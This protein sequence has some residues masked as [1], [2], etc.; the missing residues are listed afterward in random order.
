MPSMQMEPFIDGVFLH[1]TW[2][3]EA[4][5]EILRV[6]D[7]LESDELAHSIHVALHDVP[8]EAAVGFHG[9]FQVDQRALANARERCESPGFGSQIGAERARLDVERGQADAAD[10]NAVAGF[11]FV[12]RVLGGNGD[13]AIFAALLDARDA[14]YFLNNAGEHEDL[15]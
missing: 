11:Q 6:G 10:R 7:A 5:P 13:A 1:V 15:R 3:L 4:Q 8:T 9:Q 14:P 2:Q 12:R